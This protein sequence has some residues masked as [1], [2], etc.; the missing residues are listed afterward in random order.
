MVATPNLVID[1]GS[2]IAPYEQLRRQLIEQIAT[3]RL[4]A[5]TKLP[6]VRSL[7]SDLGLAP[8]TVARAY[9]ELEAEGYL[10]TKG[11]GGTL[12]A[13]I[14]A[15]DDETATRAEHLAVQYV[16]DMRALGLGDEAITGEVRRALTNLGVTPRD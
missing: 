2:S 15:I 9:K 14:A 8:G 12:V 1:A 10:I 4:P 13:P 11:R 5:H 3:R 6:A 7:A 16:R